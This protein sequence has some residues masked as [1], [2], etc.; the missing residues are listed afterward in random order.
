MG[1]DEWGGGGGVRTHGGEGV[2][3]LGHH[4]QW[5][6]DHCQPCALAIHQGGGGVAL[7]GCLTC[8]QWLSLMGVGHCLWM[9]SCCPWVL[10]CWLWVVGLVCVGGLFMAVG[11]SFVGTVVACHL[12]CSHH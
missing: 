10:G 2:V 12:L 4:C 7:G 5:V 6:W 9:L 8:G 1:S 11:L 3:L